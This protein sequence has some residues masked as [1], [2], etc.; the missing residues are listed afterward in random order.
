MQQ[1]PRVAAELLFLRTKIRRQTKSIKFARN[2]R[3][4]RIVNN[5]LRL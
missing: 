4:N 2:D 1:K 5:R 3:H